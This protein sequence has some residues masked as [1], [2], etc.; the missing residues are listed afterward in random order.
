MDVHVCQ[1]QKFLL[2]CSLYNVCI[3]PSYSVLLPFTVKRTFSEYI[4][5]VYIRSCAFSLLIF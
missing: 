3:K 1:Q 2:K 5:V 4:T